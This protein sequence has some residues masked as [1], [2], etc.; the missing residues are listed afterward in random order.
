MPRQRSIREQ[1]ERSTAILANAARM[2]FGFA[3]ENLR[4]RAK[5]HTQRSGWPSVLDLAPRSGCDCVAGAQ[6]DSSLLA[7]LALPRGDCELGAVGAERS[8]R[9]R[10]LRPLG[11]VAGW[12]PGGPHI[13]RQ[14]DP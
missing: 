9:A 3:V 1:S 11:D 8:N 10:R 6:S 14:L 12:R 7:G 5:Q 2:S 4:S 13:D